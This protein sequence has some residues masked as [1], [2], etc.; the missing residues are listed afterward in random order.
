MLAK[1]C[2]LLT[3]AAFST[4]AL[5]QTSTVNTKKSDNESKEQLEEAD[6]EKLAEADKEAENFLDYDE[7]SIHTRK[8]ARTMSLAIPAP[9]GQIT[10]RFGYPFAQ[11]K[12]IW[13]P[14][15]QMKQFE[16]ESDEFIIQW[17]REKIAKANE[18]FGCE[19][20]VKDKQ[21]VEHYRHRRWIPMPFK[22]AISTAKKDSFLKQEKLFKGVILHPIYQRVYPQKASAAHIIGYVGSKSVNLEKGPISYGDPLFWELEG[23]GGL[24]KHYNKT[25]SGTDGQRKLQ[26]DSHGREVRREDFAPKPGGTVVTTIDMA[27]QRRAESVLRKYSRRGS[28]VVIDIETGEILVMASRPS[29]DLNLWVPYMESETYKKLLNDKSK[30]FYAR[31]FQGLYP[32]ASCFKVVT[33]IAALETKAIYKNTKLDC[34]SYI[35]LGNHKFWDWSKASRGPISINYATTMS[36]NPFF[37]QAALKSEK[38]QPGRFMTVASL[39]GYGKRTGLPLDGEAKGN[40]LSNE[41]TLKKYK[42]TIKQGDVANSAIGQGPILASPLQVAQSMAGIANDGVLPT[43]HLIK[44]IQNNKGVITM[45]SKP[46]DRDQP[47]IDAAS[48]KIVKSGMYSVVNERYGTGRRGSISYALLCG[49][50]GTAQWGPPSLNQNLAWFAGYFPHKNP[51]YA[52]AVLYEGAPGETVSGGKSAAPMVPAFFNPLKGE[53]FWRHRLPNRAMIVDAGI[54]DDLVSP[55]GDPNHKPAKAMIVEDDLE[56]GTEESNAAILGS[57]PPK[58]MVVE[59]LEDPNAPAVPLEPNSLEEPTM[60]T[61]PNSGDPM[62]DPSIPGLPA[63]PAAPATGQKPPK[64]L[65]IEEPSEPVEPADPPLRELPPGVSEPV[66]PAIEPSEPDPADPASAEPSDPT[67]PVEPPKPP[68]AVPVE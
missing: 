49:K 9:R 50:T 26:Y 35:K 60:R 53:A 16:D 64:A 21:L 5:A 57:E 45:A 30:P 1:S 23:R 13:Y 40:L 19:I 43:L 39:L 38:K 46:Q 59:E 37:I 36:N 12:V 32:P 27:W 7:A 34:P 55:L 28:F 24:E 4:S 51:K 6:L 61:E 20:T 62:N 66:E 67:E 65:I 48:V 2:S 44:Q 58:A 17:C 29:Y 47:A 41:Y 54:P 18:L 52:F 68:K 11:T 33:G 14:A 22:Y 3:A 31:A 10:D 8:D 42:R 25:L 56:G 15:I 63:D